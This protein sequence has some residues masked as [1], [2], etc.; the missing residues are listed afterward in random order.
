MNDVAV[1]SNFWNE[2]IEKSW[3]LRRTKNGRD[4]AKTTFILDKDNW[5][6]DFLVWDVEVQCLFLAATIQ[7]H[8][9]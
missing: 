2:E 3:W 8:P 7:E 5:Q 6:L 9:F 1:H 4:E